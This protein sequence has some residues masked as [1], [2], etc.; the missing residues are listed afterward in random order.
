MNHYSFLFLFSVIVCNTVDPLMLMTAK[1]SELSH[2]SNK[3]RQTH[4]SNISK[5]QGF[6][7]SFIQVKQDN[8]VK[9]QLAKYFANIQN[10]VDN[11]N[12]E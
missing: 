8:G 7:T 9:D 4:M 10:D 1:S 12:N 2:Y 6:L 11:L 3:L 5:M